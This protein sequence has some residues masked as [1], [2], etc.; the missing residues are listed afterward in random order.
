MA[1]GKRQSQNNQCLYNPFQTGLRV[2]SRL[3]LPNNHSL[4]HNINNGSRYVLAVYIPYYC[5]LCPWSVENNQ[6]SFFC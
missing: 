5:L 2:A 4:S 1:L 6:V 3:V